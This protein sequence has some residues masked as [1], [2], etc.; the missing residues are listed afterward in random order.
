MTS[1]AIDGTFWAQ[2]RSDRQ[3][4]EK[5][6]RMRDTRSGTT[7][8]TRNTSMGWYSLY[9]NKLQVVSLAALPSP[10]DTS[11]SGFQRDDRSSVIP[12]YAPTS[13]Q[14]DENVEQSCKQPRSIIAKTSKKDILVVQGEWNAKVGPKAYKHK[15]GQDSTFKIQDHFV[16]SSEK[17]HCGILTYFT[18][19]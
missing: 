2:L 10:A 7:E 13:D 5:L 6:P 4:L 16:I 17:L 11:P 8:K 9:G 15:Q 19:T 14:E 3:R 18:I 12:V 1:N